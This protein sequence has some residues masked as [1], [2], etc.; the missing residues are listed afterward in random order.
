MSPA[1]L[2]K[3]NRFSSTPSS[4]LTSAPRA[5][6]AIQDAIT[7]LPS[8]SGD[9][10]PV[11]YSQLLGSLSAAHSQAL[12]AERAAD[13][14]DE[15]KRELAGEERALVI[16]D[17]TAA[18]EPPTI[19]AN[20]TTTTTQS[21]SVDVRSWIRTIQG[22]LTEV[23][24]TVLNDI[25]TG[26]PKLEELVGP[27]YYPSSGP[28]GVKANSP[29]FHPNVYPSGT[30]C[31]FLSADTEAFAW[32]DPAKSKTSQYPRGRRQY[33]AYY[34]TLEPSSRLPRYLHDC[35]RSIH[36]P[37]LDDPA[38]LE[39]YTMAKKAPKDYECVCIPISRPRPYRPRGQER[40]ELKRSFACA[41]EC[42]ERIAAEAKKWRPTRQDLLDMSDAQERVKRRNAVRE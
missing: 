16:Y 38:Q 10:D 20:V 18:T 2:A 42:R 3:R 36:F 26:L 5:S 35:R 28:P 4:S 7:T 25:E 23:Q 29:M 15:I 22:E 11:L 1:P 24:K 34:H 19:D 13:A 40:T 21:R 9:L 17:R 37:N 8:S 12:A 27:S 14:E 41:V 31:A 32:E 30:I 33:H 39:A 6:L